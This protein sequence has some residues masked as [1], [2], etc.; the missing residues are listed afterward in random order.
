M[1][2]R[3]R[4]LTAAD[5]HDTAA[6]PFVPRPTKRTR[7]SKEVTSSEFIPTT[8]NP[9]FRAGS[10]GSSDHDGGGRGG[11]GG[12]GA[13]KNAAGTTLGFDELVD[14]SGD[15][16]PDIVVANLDIGVSSA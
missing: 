16:L 14:A 6:P 10:F 8:L 1:S 13:R 12:S 2:S 15:R 3:A 5:G 7:G 9:M 11:G 4:T